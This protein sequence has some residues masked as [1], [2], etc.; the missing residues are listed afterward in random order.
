MESTYDIMKEQL[1]DLKQA[2]KSLED[3]RSKFIEVVSL[4][5][6]PYVG[7]EKTFDFKVDLK[8]DI[9]ELKQQIKEDDDEE[10]GSSESDSEPVLSGRSSMARKKTTKKV[11]S[12]SSESESSSSSV[13]SEKI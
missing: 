4:N 7:F 13:P 5:K 1:Q 12:E 9:K 11:E 10:F 8:E 3:Q 6:V 2:E